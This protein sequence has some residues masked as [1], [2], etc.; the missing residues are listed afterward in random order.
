VTGEG[1]LLDAVRVV[2]A[3]LWSDAALLYRRELELDVNKS[4][5]A[6]VIQELMET[7]RS[8]VEFGMD[9]RAPGEDRQVIEA[10]PGLCRGLVDGAVDPDRWL[11]ERS[12]GRVLEWRSGK[13]SARPES[14]LLDSEDLARIHRTLNSL[15]KRFG[16]APDLEWTGRGTDFTLLQAR[17]VTTGTICEADDRRDWYLSLR[18]GTAKLRKLCDRVVDDLIPKLEA[19]GHRLA[20]EQVEGLT[21]EELAEAIDSRAA[22][23][24]EWKRIYW[25]EFIPFAHGV[26][27]L[28]T[29]YNVIP[30]SLTGRLGRYRRLGT[31]TCNACSKR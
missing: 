21:D 12:S 26:R 6:V 25:D 30:C 14:P 1:A 24:R 4:A 10:V 11:V 16:W 2:W 19:E 31:N 22:A 13:R 23:F 27:Q 18:P 9:P 3:S 7:D 5:M 15:E 8:G 28:G 20:A 17:P 29:Y